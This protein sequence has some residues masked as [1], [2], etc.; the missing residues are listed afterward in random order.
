LLRE[1]G[2]ES[3]CHA[4]VDE[5]GAVQGHFAR[6]RQPA[7]LY[8]F[9]RSPGSVNRPRVSNRLGAGGILVTPCLASRAIDQTW[10]L[11]P[12]NEPHNR[13]IEPKRAWLWI[14]FGRIQRASEHLFSR[15]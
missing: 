8:F 7:G 3:P 6:V 1:D 12:Y 11:P 4:S 15:D 10:P 14:A 5:T 9:A 13:L 2:D